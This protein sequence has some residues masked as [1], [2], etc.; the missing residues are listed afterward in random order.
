MLEILPLCRSAVICSITG[1]KAAHGP[2]HYENWILGPV[3]TTPIYFP[4]AQFVRAMGQR[5]VMCPR[6][7][8]E[9]QAGD[10][11]SFAGRS[12]VCPGG[13]PP[14]PCATEPGGELPN[15]SLWMWPRF[16]QDLQ[17]LKGQGSDSWT[18]VMLHSLKACDKRNREA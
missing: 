2:S 18:G 17:R 11:G 9:Q 13:A 3:L 14:P 15:G 16:L 10:A 4:K 7:G 1:Y 6:S 5:E 12:A 8:A